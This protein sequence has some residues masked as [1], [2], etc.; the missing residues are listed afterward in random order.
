M[1]KLI[2]F[3]SVALGLLSASASAQ[4]TLSIK[5]NNSTITIITENLTEL[6]DMDINGALSE[7]SRGMSEAAADYSAKVAD[8]NAR[9]EAGEITEDEAEEEMDAAEDQFEEKAELLAEKIEDWSE[10]FETSIDTSESGWEAYSKQW[11]EDAAEMEAE[12][13]PHSRKGQVIRIGE[14]GIVIEDRIEEEDIIIKDEHQGYNQDMGLIGFH[15]GWNTLYNDNNELASGNAEVDFFN[16]WAYDLEFGHRVRLGETSPFIFQYGLNFSWHNIQSKYPIT[17]FQ[18]SNGE[19]AVDFLPDPNRN[20]IE[21]EFDIV[22]MD[23]PL[24]FGIDLSGKD[25][26]ENVSLLVGGYGGVRLSSERETTFTDFNEDEVEETLEDKFLSNQFRYGLM[27]QIGWGAFKVTARYDM[28]QLFQDR[29]ETPNYHLA[30]LTL[31]FVF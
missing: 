16:A 25:L 20:I 19:V 29:Y 2:P 3:L 14:N 26:N 15:F 12:D 4:D 13:L 27:G 11:E 22:Y 8:I 18:G 7:F 24:L 6:D 28:N 21:T 9:L 5:S 10:E 30:S 23:I 17:K 31:G 1:K